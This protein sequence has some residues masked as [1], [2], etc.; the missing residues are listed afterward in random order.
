MDFCKMAKFTRFALL[1]CSIAAW[2]QV[3]NAVTSTS[4]PKSTTTRKPTSAAPRTTHDLVT[5][6][7][8]IISTALP[9]DWASE[10]LNHPE[11]FQSDLKDVL[12]HTRRTLAWYTRLATEVQDFLYTGLVPPPDSTTTSTSS[13]ETPSTWTVDSALL[14]ALQPAAS[15]PTPGKPTSTPTP[16]PTSTASTESLNN[17]PDSKVSL[18]AGAKAGIGIGVSAV[19]LPVVAMAGVLLM[20]RRKKGVE[21]QGLIGNAT[22]GGGMKEKGW[23]RRGRQGV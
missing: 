23:W 21:E 8:A 14:S 5:E 9:D 4:P 17:K 16:Q 10:A 12:D 19:I 15:T 22:V 13:A 2:T 1:C 11:N 3:A 18:S 7:R 6:I 20:K